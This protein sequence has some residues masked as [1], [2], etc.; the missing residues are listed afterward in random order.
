LTTRR[1]LTTAVGQR[2][3]AADRIAKKLILDEFTKITG[4][5]RKHAIRVLTAQPMPPRDR[6]AP[7]RIYREAAKEALIVLW[8]A[9]D[10]ICGKR[11][12]NLC[13]RSCWK[14]W[15]DMGIYNWRQ[16]FEPN[17]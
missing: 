17:C 10:R 13:C 6:P 16:S 9:A 2:Y 12:K 1:E 8:E 11:L 4:Y 15:S 14:L 7:Q 3:Q 5:H